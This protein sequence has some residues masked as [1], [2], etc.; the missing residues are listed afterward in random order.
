VA[1][2][3]GVVL[4]TRLVMSRVDECE[5]RERFDRLYRC[6]GVD[7]LAYLRRRTTREVADDG[8]A[9]T[10][11]VV[12]RRLDEVPDEPRGWLL[13][14]AR[15]VLANQRRSFRRQGALVE[16]L[17]LERP[18]L[19]ATQPER[20]PVLD[21]LSQ[22][23]LLDQEALLLVAWDGLTSVEAARVLGCSA[24]AIRLRL[25]RARRR[26]ARG[27]AAAEPNPTVRFRPEEET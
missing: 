6:Y 8:L 15:R 9:E 21:A 12:W 24:V 1:E 25:H 10:F 26:L 3:L 16:R 17:I 20:D 4:D 2:T 5:R 27:L 7:V 22:L 23:R 19:V 13:A 18:L 11:L 14:I